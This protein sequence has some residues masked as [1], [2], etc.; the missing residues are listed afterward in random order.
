MKTAALVFALFACLLLPGVAHAQAAS[1]ADLQELAFRPHP[2][3]QLPLDVV[4]TDEH[5][6][7]APLAQFFTGKPVVLLLDYL[8]CKTLCGVTLQGVV[9]GLDALPPSTR[10]SVQMLAV[11]IDPRDT[12]A[13]A[14]AA[15]EKY[16]GLYHH[17]GGEAGIHLL[18]GPAGS[19]RRIADA[20]GFPY[21]YD[22]DLDQY[23]HPAGFVVAS[24]DGKIRR[25]LLGVG[26]NPADLLVALADARERRS[27]G[28]LTRILLLCHIQNLPLG[29]WTVPVLAAFTIAD[30][31]A[32]AGLIVVFA[33]IRRRR[34]G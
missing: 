25:Y 5:G 11:S 19:V 32:M 10:G 2:G 3:A 12:P 6:R 26:T 28:P 34:T 24:A 18:T 16:L 30:L 14:A 8:S 1:S 31:G 27:I 29:R 23:T 33:A 4:L 7:N 9:A 15:K 22:P 20:V 21:R 13:T 17:P